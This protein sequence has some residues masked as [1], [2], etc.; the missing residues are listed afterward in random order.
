MRKRTFNI[1]TTQIKL[2]IARSDRGRYIR[3]DRYQSLAG[4]RVKLAAIR[5]EL[6][7]TLRYSHV[8]RIISRGATVIFPACLIAWPRRSSAANKPRNNN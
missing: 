1:F 5:A 6:C 8:D 3:S 7:S 4:Y 2:V